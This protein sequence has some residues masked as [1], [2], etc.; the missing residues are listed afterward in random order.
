MCVY[1]YIYFIRVESS[2]LLSDVA[3]HKFTEETQNDRVV[4]VMLIFFLQLKSK[5]SQTSSLYISICK[6]ILCSCG[7][8]FLSL[9]EHSPGNF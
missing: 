5:I 7:V 1:I 8:G 6:I 4:C 2:C 3:F 9:S